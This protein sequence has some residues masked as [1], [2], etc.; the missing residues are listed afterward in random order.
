M[1]NVGIAISEGDPNLTTSIESVQEAIEPYDF[2]CSYREQ[3]DSFIKYSDKE[4]AVRLA[5][6][7]QNETGLDGKKIRV[8]VPHIEPWEKRFSQGL[9]LSTHILLFV[10]EL[11]LRPIREADQCED[12]NLLEYEYALSQKLKGLKK[13]ML[14]LIQNEDGSNFSCFD[15]G[16]YPSG[17]ISKVGLSPCHKSKRSAAFWDNGSK[18]DLLRKDAKPGEHSIRDTMDELFRLKG[19]NISNHSADIKK[20][21]LNATALLRMNELKVPSERLAPST[22]SRASDERAAF[23]ALLSPLGAGLCEAGAAIRSQYGIASVR[24]FKC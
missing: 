6:A 21:A 22:S 13:V 7:L 2:Y 23:A 17:D 10:S 3:T 20:V 19:V 4:T 15:T 11:G 1:E 18:G 8:Y 12:I 24:S 14:I 16:V 5:G 9:S